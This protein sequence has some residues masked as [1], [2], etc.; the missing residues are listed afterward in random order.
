MVALVMRW[1]LTCLLMS[2]L[3]AGLQGHAHAG[4]A[5]WPVEDTHGHG[6]HHAPCAPCGDPQDGGF[7]Q[8]HHGHDCFCHGMPLAAMMTWPPSL[9]PGCRGLPRLKQT[10]D[11]LPDDPLLGEDKPPLI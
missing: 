6:H 2:G 3:L 7:P 11:A 5:C 8:D 9:H 10:R 1:I 4:K